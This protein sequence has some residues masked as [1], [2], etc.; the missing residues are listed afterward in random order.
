MQLHDFIL[1]N[2][3][4]II[5][6]WEVF[7]QSCAP[8]SNTMDRTALR[9][10]VGTMLLVIAEDLKT[11]QSDA[12]QAEKSKGGAPDNR[13]VYLTPAEAHGVE[14]AESGF[15]I[16]QMAAEYR[17]LRASVLRLWTSERDYKLGPADFEDLIRFNEAV[18]QSQAESLSEFT[19]TVDNA[20]EMFLAVLGHDLRDPLAAIYSS[21]LSMSEDRDM[22][23]P[24]R[25]VA[26][27]ISERAMQ[28]TELVGDLLDFTRCRLGSGIPIDRAEIDLRKIVEDVAEEIMSAHPGRKVQIETSEEQI[29]QWDAARISQALGNLVGNAVGHSGS[30]ETVTVA[31]DGG[32]KDVAIRIHNHGKPI[33]ADR[34]DRIFNPM[35]SSASPSTSSTLGPTGS[36]GL[37][38]YIAERIVNAH[39]GW[40][41]VASSQEQGTTFTA[42][43]PRSD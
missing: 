16:E 21:V 20:K 6:E 13:K 4:Q 10:H 3:E 1:K 32:E 17:A 40:I 12:Q 22:A 37:G 9:D 36:L 25:L 38:L 31:L 15:D 14:R 5:K 23:E 2:Q 28:A 27:R 7:A 42:R 39:G 43:L 19:E 34:L 8:A 26:L 33:P 24:H 29:G 18:D 35:N 30:D 41:E 11:Y